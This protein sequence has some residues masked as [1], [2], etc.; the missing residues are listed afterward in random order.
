[1]VVAGNAGAWKIGD[2]PIGRQLLRLLDDL[3][4]NRQ[5]ARTYPLVILEPGDPDVDTGAYLDQLRAAA[6]EMNIPHV[7]PA[8]PV[9]PDSTIAVLNEISKPTA[10]QPP[11]PNFGALTFP[12]SELVATLH[13]NPGETGHAARA[14]VWGAAIGFAAAVISGI[15]QGVAGTV[16][17]PLLLLDSAL[18]LLVVLLIGYVVAQLTVPSGRARLLARVGPGSR[19]RWLATSSFFA[20]L[21]G[22]G[23]SERRRL[24]VE[25]L[26]A[27]TSGE[28]E[29]SERR[30]YLWQVRTF[31]FLEDLRAAYRRLT[32]GLGGFKRPSVPVLFLKGIS[33]ANGGVELLKAMSDIR[34]RR[35]EFHPLLVI[36]T[37]ADGAGRRTAG[38]GAAR[39]T[40]ND[41][42]KEWKES[43]GT[44]QAP[45]IGGGEPY[46]LRIPIPDEKPDEAQQPSR[47]PRR[48]PVVTW[49]WSRWSAAA[50]AFA[51]VIGGTYYHLGLVSTYC[52][53][54]IPFSANTDSWKVTDADGDTECVGV[55]TQ[56]VRFEATAD[57]V[58]LDGHRAAPTNAEL[59]RTRGQFTLADLQR[60]IDQANTQVRE[61]GKPYVTILY[62]GMLTAASGHDQA[63]VTSIRELAGAYLAQL[64]NNETGQSGTVGSALK[65]R[66][67]P[68]NVGENMAFSRPVT[69]RMLH[70]ARTDPTVIGV[71]G[72]GRNNHA[73]YHAI[74]RLSDAGVAVL[75]TVNSSDRLPILSHY[76]G[77]AS[78][79]HDEAAVAAHLVDRVLRRPVRHAMIVSRLPG[80]SG[81]I[82]SSELAADVHAQLRA[83]RITPVRYNGSDDI[84][85]QVSAACAASGA[86]PFDL[87][88]FAGR[89]EDLNGLVNALNDSGCT[90]RRMT[91]VGGDEMSRVRYGSGVYD[92][93]L[94]SSVTTYYTTFTYLRNLR[95]QGNPFFVLARNAF[96][97]GPE[98]RSLLVDGQMAL[99]FD[100]TAALAGAARKAF[101]GLDLAEQHPRVPGSQAVSAGSVLLELP[102]TNMSGAT[103]T[104]DFRQDFAHS[105]NGPGNRGLTLVKVTTTNGTPND[106]PLC[107]RLNGGTRAGGLPRC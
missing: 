100:A 2:Y 97:I 48:R 86:D 4:R 82:Y 33:E 60:R 11:H 96:G 29:E 70:I 10:W 98:Q 43:L 66:L 35:S 67:L 74:T 39:L 34:S 107:G 85:G 101:T 16:P 55:S 17:L 58:R 45:S 87:V 105:Q 99:A 20:V 78:T 23:Y 89:A 9:D 32:P 31:A 79:D 27:R 72:M 80:R 93:L 51:L 77:L 21:G 42:L 3:T 90:G 81:D 64:A 104:I 76:Y 1:M 106:H 94:P 36:A 63:T 22:H 53:V 59:S 19:Y 14:R 46:V 47:Q 61:S 12:R 57:S 69:D 28:P 30:H 7:A 8:L 38:A 88:Y 95:T 25:R 18:V 75:S 65:M 41:R 71:V 37:E 44:E 103:G 83:D 56:G 73:S 84:N 6:Q 62:A 24:V 13:E 92:V 49:A 102:S 68:V 91:L 26:T 50:V 40:V 54:A 52:Q 5:G 15:A